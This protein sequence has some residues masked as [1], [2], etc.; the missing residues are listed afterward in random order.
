V[1]ASRHIEFPSLCASTAK[2]LQTHLGQDIGRIW[3]WSNEGEIAV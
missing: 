1:P 2:H 3:L